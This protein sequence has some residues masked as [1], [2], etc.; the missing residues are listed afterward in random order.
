MGLDRYEMHTSGAGSDMLRHQHGEW[1][2]WDDLCDA[3]KMEIATIADSEKITVKVNGETVYELAVMD[4]QN[5]RDLFSVQIE[6]L[7]DRLN[8][9]FS[10]RFAGASV[11]C[12]SDCD[13]GAQNELPYWK[14][15]DFLARWRKRGK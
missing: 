6:M 2:L 13:S 7:V 5:L 1:I 9:S 15:L 10:R 8:D 12:V 3:M 14:K 4:N 11:S